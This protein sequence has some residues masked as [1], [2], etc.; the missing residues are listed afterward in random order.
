MGVTKIVKHKFMTIEVDATSIEEAAKMVY[1]EAAHNLEHYENMMVV[2][3][4]YE[5]NP[6]TGQ[7]EYKYLLG[8]G[9]K[10]TAEVYVVS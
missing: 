8:S 3:F 5:V 4:K 1:T 6:P 7:T 2:S 9:A 10:A